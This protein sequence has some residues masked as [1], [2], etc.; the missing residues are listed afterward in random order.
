M[1]TS[2]F[3]S[4]NHCTVSARTRP[5]LR[6]SVGS[7]QPAPPW[8]GLLLDRTCPTPWG[9]APLRK[10]MRRSELRGAACIAALRADGHQ[11]TRVS[12]RAGVVE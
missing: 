12:V 2:S 9:F 10:E 7:E 4:R 1:K 6:P 8:A 5:G 3:P 11:G